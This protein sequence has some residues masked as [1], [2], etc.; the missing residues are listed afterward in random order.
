MKYLLVV[1]HPDDEVL[2][3]GG[4]TYRLTQSGNDVDIC[5][6]SGKA[7]ARAF[8]PEDNELAAD[9]YRSFA[10][11]GIGKS[12]IGDFPNIKFNN[13]DHLS[14]VQFIEAAIKDS[15]PDVII[16]H[17][18]GDVNND[19]L[20]TSIACQAAIRL[21]QR[22]PEIKPLSEFWYMEV[23][24]STEWCVNEGLNK[25]NPDIFVEIGKDGVEK[26]LE[27]L[28]AYG[29]VQRPYPHPRSNEAVEGL[30]LYRGGQSGCNYAESFQLALRRIVL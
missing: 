7:A 29:G 15:Q 20:H 2:G 17:H 9:M 27:A 25:F 10:V 24:S 22:R 12:Y 13:V 5:I 16:T 6:M 18:P 14:L 11:T 19:H 8:R 26:K 3:A 23:P 21:F 28:A 1:A 4:T 30:A